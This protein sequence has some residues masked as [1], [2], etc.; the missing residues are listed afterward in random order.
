M[1]AWHNATVRLEQTHQS[2]REEVQELTNELEVKNRELARQEPPGRSGT[3]GLARRPR[4]PQQPRARHALPEPAAAAGLRR[5]GSLDIV[6]KIAS[7]FTALDVM[8]ND[9]LHFTSDRDPQIADVSA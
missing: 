9:L 5:S 7:G 3:D 1:A 8:V 2:L 6:D 4:G